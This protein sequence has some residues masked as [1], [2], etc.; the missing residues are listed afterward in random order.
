MKPSARLRA[1]V[2]GGEALNKV[3][4]SSMNLVASSVYGSRLPVL[5]T[6]VSESSVMVRILTPISRAARDMRCRLHANI[7]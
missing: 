7:S 4:V 3:P 5:N 2:F 1:W 6:V